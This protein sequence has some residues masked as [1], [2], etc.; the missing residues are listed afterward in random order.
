MKESTKGCFRSARDI[1]LVMEAV[2][3]RRA[4][5]RLPR[6]NNVVD[7]GPR[8]RRLE[9]QHQL[10]SPAHPAWP[11]AGHHVGLA[12]GGQTPGVGVSR[13]PDHAD[14]ERGERTVCT[15]TACERRR[16]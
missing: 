3:V 7:P 9:A 2:W 5:S 15:C 10:R 11:R 6:R 12:P 4:G 16:D 8:Q 1:V 13:R 14:L